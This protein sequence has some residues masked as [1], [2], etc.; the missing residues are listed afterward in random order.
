MSSASEDN[1]KKTNFHAIPESKKYWESA[2]EI[3]SFLQII[4]WGTK[5]CLTEK[6]LIISRVC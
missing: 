3:I 4:Y 2:H 1:L 6:Q 5:Q